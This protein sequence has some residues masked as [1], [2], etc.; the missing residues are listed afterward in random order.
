MNSQQLLPAGALP[1]RS[2]RTPPAAARPARF[3]LR[4]V[5]DD[6]IDNVVARLTLEFGQQLRPEF[7]RALV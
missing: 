5:T 1:V 4:L 6:V 7:I 2:A 3:H